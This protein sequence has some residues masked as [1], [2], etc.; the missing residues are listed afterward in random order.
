MTY[1]PSNSVHLSSSF[2]NASLI[3]VKRFLK[4]MSH[5]H[6]EVVN[7]TDLEIIDNDSGLPPFTQIYRE[8]LVLKFGRLLE[9]RG[10]KTKFKNTSC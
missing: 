8:S 3:R 7:A 9:S 5:G 1:A 4:R 6:L 10:P 2:S